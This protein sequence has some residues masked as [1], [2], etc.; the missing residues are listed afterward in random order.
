[1]KHILVFAACAGLALVGSVH[2]ADG[3]PSAGKAA[4]A[5]C[6]ACHGADGNS[7]NP[8]WPKIAGQHPDYLA[9]QLADFK[10]GADRNNAL[11]AGQVAGMDQKTMQDLAAYFAQQDMK[12]GSANEELVNQ[13]EKIYRAGNPTSGV[14]ACISCHGPGGQ[15]NP[16][17]NFPR[18]GGQHATY[19]ANQLGA[20]RTGERSNDYGAMMRNI[21]AKMTDQEI[22]AVSAYIEGLHAVAR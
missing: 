1:M 19:T 5:A 2:A 16:A 4:A 14:A 11:M 20:F 7:S 3:D 8:E 9:K 22:K 15:G 18:L 10:A 17:A 13:G 12:I 6:A 21:A